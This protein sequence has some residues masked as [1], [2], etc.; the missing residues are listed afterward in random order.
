MPAYFQFYLHAGST[1]TGGTY[2]AG[3]WQTNTN[4]NFAPGISSFVDATSRTLFI[5]GCQLE[6]SD[7]ATPFEHKT[8]SQDLQ[9]NLCYCLPLQC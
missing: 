3:T 5:T 7:A 1:Y 9:V 8:V 4:A 2:T 6:V